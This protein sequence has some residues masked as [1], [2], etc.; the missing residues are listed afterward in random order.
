MPAQVSFDGHARSTRASHTMENQ[1]YDGTAPLPQFIRKPSALKSLW[2]TSLMVK[3]GFLQLTAV[4]WTVA[5]S[6]GILFFRFDKK[7]TK[8][9]W[10][11][12]FSCLIGTSSNL[13]FPHLK[14]LDHHWIRLNLNWYCKLR[15]LSFGA[16]NQS[17]SESRYWKKIGNKLIYIFLC[18]SI[19]Q[20]WGRETIFLCFF[21]ALFSARFS[22]QLV[23]T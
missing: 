15:F 23:L 1:C 22:K 5:R 17:I 19:L 9:F 21:R 13:S 4:C 10:W 14:N 18:C 6:I 3:N 20:V 8:S 12:S 7:I 11:F 2:S 16:R